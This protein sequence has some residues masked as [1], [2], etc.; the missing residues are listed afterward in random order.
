MNALPEWITTTNTPQERRYYLRCHD[1]LLTTCIELISP[2]RDLICGICGGPLDLLGVV[3]GNRWQHQVKT[4]VCNERC[5][6]ATGPK[7][8]CSCG[9]E[10]HGK[11]YRY[12]MYVDAQGKVNIKADI[13]EEKH[14]KI[15]REYRAAEQDAVNRIN[16]LPRKADYDCGKYIPNFEWHV[17]HD[18]IVELNSARKG[19]QQKSRLAKLNKV[20][21]REYKPLE[22][23]A[24]F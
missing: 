5:Q 22:P 16:A 8:T 14:I 2:R 15:A 6:D 9:G 20:A 3:T 17:I 11:G 24:Q 4:C 10:N 18:A 1:C 13:D 12:Q 19:S 7:C 23:I 21:R